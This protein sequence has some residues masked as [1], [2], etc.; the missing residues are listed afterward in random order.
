LTI[1][2]LLEVKI[3]TV[4]ISEVDI[5]E[6]DISEVDIS[7]VDISDIR[8]FNVAPLQ[9]GMNGVDN[10]KLSFA[11]VRVPRENLLNKFS[12]ITPDGKFVTKIKV[13]PGARYYKYVCKKWRPAVAQ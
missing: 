6:V 2:E 12:D 3:L 9:M 11:N 5:S 13:P 10:A 7:E 1:F 4:D 8:R